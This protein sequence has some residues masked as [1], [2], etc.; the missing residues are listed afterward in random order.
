MRLLKVLGLELPWVGEAV[1]RESLRRLGH[2][3]CEYAQGVGAISCKQY[4]I[5]HADSTS[6]G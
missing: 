5:V 3:T 6:H 4:A 1:T 2:V